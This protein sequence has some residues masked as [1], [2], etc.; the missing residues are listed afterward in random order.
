MIK[1]LNKFHYLT[2]FVF[3]VSLHNISICMAKKMKKKIRAETA[4]L[5]L[6][7]ANLYSHIRIWVSMVD[8]PAACEGRMAR[9]QVR[10]D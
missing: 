7:P 6:C 2:S 8:V 1:F 9:A 10:N 5:F 4:L 3:L